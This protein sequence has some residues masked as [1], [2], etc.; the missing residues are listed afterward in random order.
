MSNSPNFTLNKQIGT[1]IAI[2]MI[3][4]PSLLCWLYGGDFLFGPFPFPILM[5]I[6]GVGGAIS[7]AAFVEKE[8]QRHALIPGTLAGLGATVS[9]YFYVTLL[10]RTFLFKGEF[11]IVMAIGS[12]PGILLW[13]ILRPRNI[14]KRN[15]KIE[16]ITVEV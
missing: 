8:N 13:T 10:H 6:S 15:E 16:V 3:I 2:L 4:V 9:L 5:I 7:L 14:P 12:L 1:I 11:A